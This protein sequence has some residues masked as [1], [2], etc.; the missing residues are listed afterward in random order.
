[1]ARTK[2]SAMTTWLWCSWA[3]LSN[4]F[5]KKKE[6][7]IFSCAS[8]S[9]LPL[10]WMRSYQRQSMMMR[11]WKQFVDGEEAKIFL[12]GI[13]QFHAHHTNIDSTDECDRQNF[14]LNLSACDIEFSFLIISSSL[15]SFPRVG[16]VVWF[17]FDIGTWYG[18]FTGALC[19][20]IDY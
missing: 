16:E 5:D 7:R 8:M 15:S 4:E 1:M 18:M 9:I 17:T 12:N 19:E 6:S 11:Y 20:K 10:E 13:S 14:L 3:L 2:G